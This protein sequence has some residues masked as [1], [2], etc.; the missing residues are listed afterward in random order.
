MLQPLVYL[1]LELLAIDGGSSTPG[2]CRV[3]ALYHEVRDD[4]VEGGIGIVIA[5]AELD[6][7]GAGFWSMGVV[8]FDGDGSLDSVSGL[9]QEF[10][11]EKQTIEVSMAMSVAI[12]LE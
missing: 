5:C 7:V 3:S 12:L 6:E 10:L 4:A 9:D 11:G 8:E 1:I 2:T